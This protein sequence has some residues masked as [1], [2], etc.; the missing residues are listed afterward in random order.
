C[1]NTFLLVLCSSSTKALNEVFTELKGVHGVTSQNQRSQAVEIIRSELDLEAAEQSQ[2]A[3]SF[4]TRAGVLIGIGAILIG[5][6]SSQS[7]PL[8]LSA[9]IFAAAGAVAAV[10]AMVPR[11]SAGLD[12]RIMRK[13]YLGTD[14]EVTRLRILDTR[15]LL[16]EQD[17]QRLSTK[18][19]WLYVRVLLIG[20]GLLLQLAESTVA[21]I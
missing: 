3:D 14:P 4:D 9:H 17:E 1:I 15:I 6:S 19:V 21:Y 16:Y 12:P 20:L 2:R 18:V 10:I 7:H 8:V 13:K 11:V 5:L